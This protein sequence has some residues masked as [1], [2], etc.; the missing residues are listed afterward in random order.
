[1]GVDIYCYV[2]RRTE[3]GWEVAHG[4]MPPWRVEGVRSFPLDDAEFFPWRNYAVFS[5]LAGVRS[6]YPDMPQMSESRGLPDDLSAEVREENEDHWGH[7]YGWL[8]TAELAAFDYEQT[9]AV[10]EDTDGTGVISLREYLG[11]HYFE[12][13]EL[14]KAIDGETRIVFWFS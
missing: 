11:K 13:L 1:M 2:E 7:A 6:E 4:T 12:R 10:E 14:L 3:V 9:F 5:F 8:S